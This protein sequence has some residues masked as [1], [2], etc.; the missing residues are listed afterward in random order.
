MR[1]ITKLRPNL[2][3]KFHQKDRTQ[4]SVELIKFDS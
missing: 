2:N 1:I 4:I 3:S